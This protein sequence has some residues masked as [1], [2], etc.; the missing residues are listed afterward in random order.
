[1][2]L[3][4]EERIGYELKR[5]QQALRGAMEGTLRALGLTPAGYAALAVLEEAPGVSSA[6]LARRSFVTAQTMGGVL[7]GLERAGLVER[8]AHPEHGRILETALTAGGRS[9]VAE[10]HER[11]GAIEERMLA[12]LKPEERDV[13]LDLLHRSALALER[14]EQRS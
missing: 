11:V 8:R 4:T 1:M 10:A 5:A 12:E 6:E 9:L 7:G 14:T 13:L 3:P 2:V